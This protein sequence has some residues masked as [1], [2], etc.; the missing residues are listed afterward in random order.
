MKRYLT[1][2]LGVALLPLT[3]CSEGAA[4]QQ[5]S[6]DPEQ[7]TLQVLAAASLNQPFEEIAEDFTA[8]HP[9]LSIEISYAGS[10]T[11]VQNLQAGAPADVLATADEVSMNTANDAGLIDVDSRAIFASNTLVGIV[12]A[13]NPASVDS[14]QQAVAPEV[15]LVTCA[16]QV[17]CGALSQAVAEAAGVK[18]EPVSE[19]LQVSDVLGKVRSGQADAGLVYATEAALAP[20]EVEVFHI[21]GAD[22]ARNFYP[23]AQTSDTDQPEAS[24]EFI[25][26]VQSDSGQAVLEAHGFGAP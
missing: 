17:P 26:Y 19:E 3:G 12:P 2:F 10:S 6:E 21:D 1:A 13:D 14:L 8:A 23:I 20:Q 16:P 7:V 25:D 15:N 18:L 24:A 22:D 9:E 4:G 11:L 5:N